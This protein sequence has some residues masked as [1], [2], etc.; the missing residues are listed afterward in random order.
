MANFNKEI[1]ARL[2]SNE[3]DKEVT[4]HVFRKRKTNIAKKASLITTGLCLVILASLFSTNNQLDPMSELN[5]QITQV[6]E[7]AIHESTTL[8]SDESLVV[9]LDY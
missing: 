7:E 8:F 9:Y 1:E 2:S 6:Y 5:T 4:N 3:W